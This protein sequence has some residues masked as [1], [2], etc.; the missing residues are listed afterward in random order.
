M[1]LNGW[2]DGSS[3]S[4]RKSPARNPAHLVE[5]KYGRIINAPQILII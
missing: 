3:V 2:I 1:M 5:T 4:H